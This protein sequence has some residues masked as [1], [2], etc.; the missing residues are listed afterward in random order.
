MVLQPFVSTTKLLMYMVYGVFGS[1]NFFFCNYSTLL[2]AVEQIVANDKLKKSWLKISQSG[3]FLLWYETLSALIIDLMTMIFLRHSGVCTQNVKKIKKFSLLDFAK[4]IDS[5]YK[6][7]RLIRAIKQISSKV[8]ETSI[9]LYVSLTVHHQMDLSA[10]AFS[11]FFLY[12]S[13]FTWM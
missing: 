10:D 4:S 1:N 12:G 11:D 8:S 2:K 9:K 6:E 5:I 13:L 3:K 7:I